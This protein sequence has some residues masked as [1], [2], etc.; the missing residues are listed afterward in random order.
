MFE[1]ACTRV[2]QARSCGMGLKDEHASEIQQGGPWNAQRVTSGQQGIAGYYSSSIRPYEDGLLSIATGLL[3]TLRL[4]LWA[5]GLSHLW[6]PESDLHLELHPYG[7]GTGA[8]Y[9]Y[10]QSLLFN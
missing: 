2:N 4:E 6:V 5:V 3:N 1:I 8:K 10:Y 7:G 9:D